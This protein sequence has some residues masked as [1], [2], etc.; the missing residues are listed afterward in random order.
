MGS[1]L[2]GER[3]NAFPLRTGTRQDR[4]L[5]LSLL[6]NTVLETLFNV[7]RQEKELKDNHV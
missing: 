6:F 7:L 2:N 5:F 4:D 1:I 3:L